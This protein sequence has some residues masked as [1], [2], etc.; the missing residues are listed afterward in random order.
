MAVSKNSIPFEMLS[1]VRAALATAK[2]PFLLETV[3]QYEEADEPVV[4]FSAHQAPIEVLAARPG[5]KA[6]YGKTPG[7]QRD[8]IVQAFQAGELRGVACSIR[9]AGVGLTLTRANTLIFNDKEFVPALNEQAEDR[10]CRIGQTRGCNIVTIEAD[11]KIDRRI[12]EILATKQAIISASV[13][14]AQAP[15]ATRTERLAVLVETATVVNEAAQRASEAPVTAIVRYPGIVALMAKASGAGLKFP[16]F[17]IPSTK[18]DVKLSLARGGRHIGS[19]HVSDNKGFGNAYYGRIEGQGA[20]TV[21]DEA[22]LAALDAFEANPAEVARLYGIQSGCCCFCS[23]ELTN[24]E[25]TSVGYGPTCAAR[26][27]MPWGGTGAVNVTAHNIADFVIK[28]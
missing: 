8:A 21:R 20:T 14:R 24:A 19:I 4:V 13:E 12:N 10:I 23:K 28:T 18:G 5:W 6:I 1:V 17:L 2:I 26:F 11:H 27:G 7:E 15:V 9:A 22:I 3:E 16:K 25:S